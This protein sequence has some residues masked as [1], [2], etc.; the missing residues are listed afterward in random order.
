MRRH[1]AVPFCL[2][3]QVRQRRSPSCNRVVQAVR[4]SCTYSL[5]VSLQAGATCSIPLHPRPAAQIYCPSILLKRTAD[6]SAR[7]AGETSHAPSCSYA[8]LLLPEI[9]AA[10]SII[11]TRTGNVATFQAYVESGRGCFRIRETA[12]M[13]CIYSGP[14]PTCVHK[15][16]ARSF[17]LFFSGD[18][19]CRCSLNQLPV[20][21][22]LPFATRLMTGSGTDFV[23][24]GRPTLAHAF[25]SCD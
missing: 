17:R 16:L 3:P 5:P 13:H 2:V 18:R 8:C 4:A 14:T 1:R 9:Q 7:Y 11:V 22:P 24:C 25:A 21:S 10:G 12:S 6:R 19:H 23:S 15:Q 20:S